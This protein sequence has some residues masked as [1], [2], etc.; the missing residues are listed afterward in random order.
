MHPQQ[1]EYFPAMLPRPLAG[2]AFYLLER[3]DRMPRAVIFDLDGTLLNT[4]DDLADAANWVCAQNGWPLHTPEEYKHFV[5]RGIPNLCRLFSPEAARGKEKQAAVLAAF[6][7]RYA[8]HKQDKTAPYPGIEEAVRALQNAGILCGVLSNK[9]DSLAK[10]VVAH[11]FPGLFAHVQGAIA[12]RPAKPNP[13]GVYALLS[14]MGAVPGPEAMLVG[15]SDVDV[16]TGKNAGLPVC[17]ALWGFRGREELAAAGA[18]LLAQSP[19]EMA[20]LLL[21]WAKG[22]A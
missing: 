8:A 5:G 9:D 11:Y 7:A 3:S 19:A 13:A 1:P 12:G 20:R 16:F 17:G 10:A 6:L 18:S 14:E 22:G 15:D 21:A 4:I 2:K